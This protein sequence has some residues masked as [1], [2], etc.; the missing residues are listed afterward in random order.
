MPLSRDTR[1]DR[2]RRVLRE[3]AS[4]NEHSQG[5]RS[6]QATA[7]GQS[8]GEEELPTRRSAGYSQEVRKACSQRLVQLI[9]VR[10]LSFIAAC[11]A[12]LL[13]PCTLMV[14]HYMIYVSGSLQWYGQPLAVALDASHPSSIA[15][16][17]GSHLWLLCLAAT[18]LTFQLRRHK[19]DDYRGEYRLWFWLVL[20]CLLASV[21]STTHLTEL[22]GLAVDPWSQANLGLSG[23]ALTTSTLTVLIG[24]LGLRLC[25]ELKAV[26]LSLICWLTGIAAWAG[27]GA[28]AQEELQ[29]KMTLQFRIWLKS[30]LWIGGLTA[31]WIAALSYLRAVYRDAQQRFLSRSRLINAKPTRAAASGQSHDKRSPDNNGRWKFGLPS[32][33]K[34]DQ[35]GDD[36]QPK[37]RPKKTAGQPAQATKKAALSKTDETLGNATQ[38]DARQGTSGSRIGKL[39][40]RGSKPHESEQPSAKDSRPAE[41]SKQDLENEQSEN[42]SKN[43]FSKWLKPPKHDD[44]ASEFQKVPSRRADQVAEK[45]DTD[46]DQQPSKATKPTSNSSWFKRKADKLPAAAQNQTARKKWFSSSTQS[47]KEDGKSESSGNTAKK[48]SGGLF[49]RFKLQPPEES[50]I[51]SDKNDPLH[52]KNTSQAQKPAAPKQSESEDTPSRPMTKAERRKM[53]RLQQKQNRAA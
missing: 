14:F 29:L 34:R 45:S 28:L 25:S 51:D 23:P 38:K 3:T 18:V 42:K 30:A 40:R 44:N 9:P 22:F 21:D 13:V 4:P 16:W 50:S 36:Q 33:A 20:T 17:F 1:N 31:V 43:R 52:S 48:K 37:S 10:P 41:D 47:S 5:A 7:K 6:K 32:L 53:R 49:A 24:M 26:P 35:D 39:F 19:L 27:S 2:R 15:A 12:S 8:T 46:A 11:L